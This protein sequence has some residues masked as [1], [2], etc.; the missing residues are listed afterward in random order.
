MCILILKNFEFCRVITIC[1]SIY[2]SFIIACFRELQQ[3]GLFL[4]SLIMEL[5]GNLS[6]MYINDERLGHTIFYIS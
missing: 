2:Y 3:F 1:I 4:L 5:I 6:K